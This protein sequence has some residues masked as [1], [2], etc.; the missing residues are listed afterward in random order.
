MAE[1]TWKFLVFRQNPG[2]AP[3]YE[4]Y[5]VPDRPGLTTLDALFYI[6]DYIDP[7]LAFRYSCRGA[8][9]GSCGITLDKVPELACRSQVN[10]IKTRKK[11]TNLPEFVFGDH[12]DWNIDEEILVEPLPNM[13]VIRDLV[14]DMEPFW[15]FYREVRPFFTRDWQ[16]T[17]PESTQEAD[18]VKIFERKIYCILCGICWAC[19]ISHV[20]PNYLGPAA[21]AKAH[22]FLSDSRLLDTDRDEI[23]A[24]IVKDDAVPACEKFFVCN[25]VCPKDVQPG[26]SI[27][28]IRK[29]WI[30]K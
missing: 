13:A 27:Q 18:A 23:V 11:P 28:E 25:R 5:D 8:I 6:Q 21:L 7:T 26:T 9:C 2:E 14:V 29:G 12:S 10:A 16:D 19:P 4:R 20:N 15:K 24:R 22:R 1:N 30:D 3:R 17:P